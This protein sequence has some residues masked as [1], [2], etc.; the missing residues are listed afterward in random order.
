MPKNVSSGAKAHSEL[1]LC[2]GAKAPT[3]KSGFSATRLGRE[4]LEENDVRGMPEDVGDGTARLAGD[5]DLKKIRVG[6]KLG[7]FNALQV[8]VERF[9]ESQMA[10]NGENDFVGRRER[11]FHADAAELQE[12]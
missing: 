10:Q 12:S 11:G 5:D 8:V 9:R 1:C 6:G 7:K 2:V 4:I 3:P